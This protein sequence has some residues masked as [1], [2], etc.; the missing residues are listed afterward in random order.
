[1][2]RAELLDRAGI[3]ARLGMKVKS[4]DK[5]RERSNAEWK[6][7]KITH[8]ELVAAIE[9]GRMTIEAAAEETGVG[10][11]FPEPDQI[12]ARTPLWKPSRIDKFERARKARAAAASNGAKIAAHAGVERTAR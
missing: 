2:A 7:F 11:F 8:P 9:D 10:P 4:V 12:Y 3:A 6:A 5:I 1:M